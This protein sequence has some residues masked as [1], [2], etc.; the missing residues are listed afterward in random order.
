MRPAR[1]V[2]GVR[3][4]SIGALL[5]LTATATP[6]P[7]VDKVWSPSDPGNSWNDYF[8]W[9]PVTAVAPVNPG[10]TATFN[11]ATQISPTINAPVTI[12]SITFVPG[13]SVFSI[14]VAPVG[15]G[16]T[17]Q[18]VGIVNNSGQTQT[19]INGALSFTSFTTGATAGNATI[20]NSG[21]GLTISLTSFTTGATAGNA[22]INN[23]GE[24]CFTLFTTGATAGNATIINSG[25]AS[26]T[27]FTGTGVT[28]G[29]ATIF[30]SGA[31]TTIL[32]DT[33]ASAGSAT[34]N[35]S[36]TSNLASFT[37]GASAANATVNNSGTSSLTSFTGGATA[38]NATIFNS[39][40]NSVTSFEGATA[41]N[42]T[43]DNSGTSSFTLF[44]TGATAENATITNSGGGSVTAFILGASG[45]NAALINANP[46]AFITIAEL[47]GQGTTVGSIAGSGNLFLG[48]KNLTVGGNQQSTVFTG[49]ISDVG[50]SL[51]KVGTGTLTLT[52]INTYTGGTNLDGG[53]L[54]VNSDLN[55]GT[56]PLS[57]NGGTLEAL[58]S[59]GGIT[60]SKPVSLAA[61]GGTFLADA[62]TASTLSEPITGG[63]A[64]TKAGPGTLT[65]TGA[66]TYG[67]GTTV[68]AGTLQLGAGGTTGSI[69]GNVANNGI[70]AFNRS[71]V[72]TFGGVIS[73]TGS[74]QQNGTGTTVLTGNNTYTG[75]TT[76]NLGTLQLGAGGTTGSITGNV[77][78]N[79]ILA[80]NRSDVF[81]FGGVISGTGSVQQN[82]IG[83]TVLTGNNTYTGGTTINAG[84]LQL[85]AGGTTGSI[86]GNV[87][88][89]GEL[90]FNRSDAVT[91]GGVISG[92]GTLVKLGAGTL[93]L[94]SAN[95]YTGA[96]TVNGGSLIVDGSIASANTL[97]NPGGL[98]GGQGIIGG[99][100]V[101]GGVVSPGSSPGTLTV[102]GDYTQNPN[103]T[104][105]IEVA[106][107]APSQHDVLAVNGHASVAGTVQLVRVGG[108]NLRLGDQITFLTATSGV[109]GTFGNVEN[110][111]LATGS[112][113]VFDVVYL[114]NAIVLKG[115]QGSFAEFALAFFGTPNSVAVGQALDSAVG[116]PQTSELIGFLNNRT[117]TDLFDALDLISPEELTSIFVIGVSLA[118]V[119]TANLE[120]RM[121]DIRRGSTGFSSSGFAINGSGPSFSEG[122]AGVSGPEGKSGPP[123]FAPIPQNRW[124]VFVTGIGE[125]TDVD[126]TFNASGY[127]LA[128]GGFTT[129]I[130]YRIGSHFAIGLTG[131][132]AYTHA[133]LVNDSSIAVNGGKLGLY[134]T[135]FGSGFYLDTAVI[136][137]LNGYDTRRTALQGTASGD[138]LG[139]DL[140][141]LVAAGYDWKKGGLSIGPTASFQYTLVGF[142]D[143]TETGSLAPLAFPDQHAESFRTAFGMKASYDWKI[144]PIHLIPEVRLAWQHEFGDTDYSLVSSFAN[145][146]GNTFTVNG[147]EIGRDSMLL[148]AGFAIHWNDRISTYAYY[149]GELFRTNYLS[150]NVSAG[151]RV[152]F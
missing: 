20:I 99:N 82:G 110:D 94:P 86:V 4:K 73:G 143:F 8:N 100:L 22:T 118:N 5:L 67:G 40:A 27:N 109:S 105:R 103:G 151:F 78:N 29:N 140:N 45:G 97:V 150:N 7:A 50:G 28:A 152:N 15:V 116:D 130:D 137:G 6:A 25:E 61:G 52:G 95:T 125:F 24:A 126:S 129:G 37:T 72:F 121:D 108:F 38:G 30:N 11:G 55:L 139:G 21:S 81:T 136:G 46:T 74:V 128:T 62:G 141:V 142:G 69:T 134:A 43:I 56:G 39:G 135:A 54:A 93:T 19:I 16:L 51:T 144:G 58:G 70:L 71:D 88:D 114:P 33:G 76:I 83:T 107:L 57:F 17:L 148:G 42:A 147:A 115:T 32:F 59:G 132:Y 60:S 53:I 123:V 149:D 146:A 138:T 2:D 1:K 102:N 65:L 131:G 89:N 64:W 127:D 85:G 104:L 47:S 145:R 10:D 84:T 120:R 35:N 36:G 49:V 111:F 23:S 3:T 44:T 87:I 48:S 13:A 117:L 31:S 9:S 124:G 96:T 90:I 14:Q 41:G 26:F 12:D 98:L 18:G 122:F 112:I 106:G 101:N 119:Q 63:G 133:D 79:G 80:F 77:A 66:N 75:G 91:F 68:S 34:I 92:T 113:V